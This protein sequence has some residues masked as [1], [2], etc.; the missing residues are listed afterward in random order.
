MVSKPGDEYKKVT[1]SSEIELEGEILPQMC[2][3]RVATMQVIAVF[4]RGTVYKEAKEAIQLF[5][6]VTV[7]VVK[8]KTTYTIL[9]EAK[10]W[11]PPSEG[12]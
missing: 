10:F 5:P 8:V 7:G 3:I 6:G 1:V 12:K 2:A 11:P 4:P 9:E